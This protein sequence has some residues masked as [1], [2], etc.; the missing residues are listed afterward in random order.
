LKSTPQRFQSPAL[1]FSAKVD[2]LTVETAGKQKLP[3]MKGRPIWAKSLGYRR[4]SIHDAVLAD[5]VALS[6]IF[7]N[8]RLHEVEI[9]VDI[10]VSGQ[11]DRDEIVQHL[12]QIMTDTFAKRLDPRA[13]LGINARRR[14]FYR[15]LSNDYT[16]APFN[17]VAPLPT[18]QLLYGFRDELVQVKCYLKARDQNQELNPKAFSARVEVRMRGEVLASHG[19]VHLDDLVD[20]GFRKKLMPY[21]RHIRGSKRTSKRKSAMMAVLLGGQECFDA[22]RWNDV[23]V[24]A[25]VPG[26]K[27]FKP[28]VRLLRDVGTNHR[29]GQALTRLEQRFARKKIVRKKMPAPEES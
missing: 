25:F 18:D 5:V 15:R 9:A 6:P 21:F 14:A 22:H 26:G 13:G 10:Q 23:G 27:S 24:G 11:A 1:K 29:I 4:L 17:M 16:V 12:N 20:F 8:P 2:Y 28:N 3:V 7:N 19:L